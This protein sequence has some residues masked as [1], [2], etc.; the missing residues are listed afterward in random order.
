MNTLRA[1]LPLG[2]MLLALTTLWSGPAVSA[3]APEEC[4]TCMVLEDPS[5]TPTDVYGVLMY[6]LD[7]AGDPPDPFVAEA[8]REKRP[9]A[10]PE[11]RSAARP[12]QEPEPARVPLRP[13][14]LA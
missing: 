12:S 10:R 6:R 2:L 4:V 11:Q 13:P 9:Q 8:L 1:L 7:L 5:E 14:R 3:D